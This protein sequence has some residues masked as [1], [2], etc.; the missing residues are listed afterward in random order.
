MAL[1][2]GNNLVLSIA[3]EP[4]AIT[5]EDWFDV[6][7][8]NLFFSGGVSADASFLKKV[9]ST[10]DG[11]ATPW[12]QISGTNAN[13]VL[14]GTG[15]SELFD[16][17]GG[18]DTIDSVYG[19]DTIVF[20][21]GY[22]ALEVRRT[23]S[24]T[25]NAELIFGAGIAASDIYIGH[26]AAGSGI[27]MSLSNGDV[28]TLDGMLD[29]PIHRGVQ[30]VQFSDGTVWT[31]AEILQRE[32]QGTT[33][34][35]NIAGSA[36]DSILDGKGG[37]DK[38]IG[39]SGADTFVYNEGYGRL[40]AIE[41]TGS[42]SNA[43]LSFGPNIT[44]NSISVLRDGLN[45]VILDGVDGDKVQLDGMLNSDG[46]L[47]R[48]NGVAF[49][50]FVDGITLTAD[51]LLSMS[52]ESGGGVDLSDTLVGSDGPELF[53]GGG[54][55]DYI[56]GG[57]GSDT[58]VYNAGYGA[59]RIYETYTGSPTSVLRLGDGMTA[60]SIRITSGF[61]GNDIVITDGIE[62]DSITLSEM[63]VNSAIVGIGG[64]EFADGSSLSSDQIFHMETTGTSASDSLYGTY[65]NDVF[66]GKGGADYVYE[67]GGDDTIIFNKGYGNVEVNGFFNASVVQLG[68]G[69]T[70]DNLSVSV[71][72]SNLVLTDGVSGDNVILDNVLS[73]QNL[74][75]SSTATSVYFADGSSLTATQLFDLSR[76]LRGTAGGDYLNAGDNGLVLDGKG[77]NDTYHSYY[78][79]DTFVFN[80][81]YGALEINNENYS[82][83]TFASVLRFGPGVTL[84][85]LR[86]TSDG[87]VLVLRDGVDGDA[88]TVD[89]FFSEFGWAGITS[90]EL[91]D[92][93]VLNV[94]QLIQLEET[95]STGA[96]TLYGTSGADTIDGRGGNDLAIG[97]GGADT[98]V[99]NAGYGALEISSDE[100]STP[101]S[102]LRFGE[103]ITASSITV[104]N[105]NSG[106]AI[107]ITDGID[108]DV[109]TIDNMYS[110]SGTKGVGSVE[111]FDGTTLTAQ[112]LIALNAGRAPEA[113]YYGT[114]GADSITGSGEDELF[115]GKGGTDYVKGNAG[116]DTFV[117]NQGYGALE[118]DE[119]W[120]SGQAPVLQLGAGIEASMLKVSVA[121]SHSGLV[122]TDGVAG[123]Q[124]TLDNMLYDYQGVST[125]RFADGSTLSKAQIIAMETTGTSGADSMYGTTAAELF[126]GKGGADYAKGSG[127]NDT[128][129]FNEGYGQLEIDETLNDGATTVLQLGAGITRENIKAYF[130]GATL[131]LT[132]GISGDQIRIDNEK[133]SNNGI[134]LVQFADEATLTQA[135]LQTLPTTGS[136]G[137]DSLTGTGDSR[138][139]DGKGGN[140]TVN[141][142]IGNDT[143]VYNQ[144]H[145]ALEINN[146][147][148][149]GQNPVLQLGAGITAADLQVTTDAS[150]CRLDS[151]RRRRG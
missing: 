101:T 17:K 148:W 108:G 87:N 36:T 122:I 120:Y 149:Y 18:N 24:G 137:N 55:N 151:D 102:V 33:G 85:S 94:S 50:T 60:A 77:G 88:V 133:Y 58:F 121:N 5:L 143:F 150:Q 89:H 72:G 26:D 111:F 78:A 41:N 43:T 59:L 82:G 48:E 23:T 15:Q 110:D 51:Q 99:Y 107:Q 117:F 86:V 42:Q 13:D 37:R 10:S 73:G 30:N 118:V 140:D 80:S 47:N 54:G 27:T 93:T 9:L 141:G 132:D 100:G 95:G 84:D 28:V 142:N 113:T 21:K 131:V 71:S 39:R 62:D 74:N 53:D 128:F 45:L 64:I 96:D 146:N 136:A 67:G 97:N 8:L 44:A 19:A 90:V 83:G 134:N 4:G 145:G 34:N 7:S 1:R 38:L 12:N 2:S 68:A 135:D 126:D 119:N 109:I 66:D 61:Y 116:N 104:R 52:V 46:T 127:G 31:A 115:D 98:F 20:N 103:G 22:G 92:G 35:D 75:P 81:G 79:N 76:T 112:Q 63:L 14:T 129:V 106:T 105:S 16:G 6:G 3:G 144:G 139:I 91:N 40:E 147:Y 65:R 69:I 56:N 25:S 49:A 29:D 123:D 114:T 125:I 138:V 57:G 11:T 130:D 124:I 32:M 70:A